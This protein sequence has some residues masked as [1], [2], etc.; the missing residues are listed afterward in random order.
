LGIAETEWVNRLAR[1]ESLDWVDLSSISFYPG[2]F[3]LR[4]GESAEGIYH[5]SVIKDSK[6]SRLDRFSDSFAIRAPDRASAEFTL[7]SQTME[8]QAVFAE[9]EQQRE[10]VGE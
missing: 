4:V 1:R 2:P 6:R 3:F 5:R 10:H 8:K 9:T 7:Y